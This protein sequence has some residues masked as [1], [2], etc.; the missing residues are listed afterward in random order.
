MSY[1]I[2]TKQKCEDY[3]QLV[4]E[5]ENYQGST[6]SWASIVHHPTIE[7][8]CAIVKHENYNAAMEEVEVLSED[9]NDN[10]LN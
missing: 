5:G 3:N 9:W 7:D 6:T 2:G 4:T 10:N 1:Y 8:K